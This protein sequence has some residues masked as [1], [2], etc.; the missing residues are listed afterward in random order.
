VTRPVGASL[1]DWL[2]KPSSANGLG[3]GSGRVSIVLA[4]TI[5]GV[6]TYLAVTR[7]DVQQSS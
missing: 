5:A 6:V 3:W 1:A 4:L 7:K 2:G